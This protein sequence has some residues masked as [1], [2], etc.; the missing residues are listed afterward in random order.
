MKQK[1]LKKFYLSTVSALLVL[2]ALL[3]SCKNEKNPGEY[4]NSDGN[5]D[6]LTEIITGADTTTIP[7][8][9]NVGETTEEITTDM[10]TTGNDTTEELIKAELPELEGTIKL[11]ASELLTL[12]REG[13]V[14]KN[15][16]YE[17]TD[18]TG[19]IFDRSDDSKNYDC[20]NIT[21]YGAVEGAVGVV[22]IEGSRKLTLSTL[23]WQASE[24]RL[25]F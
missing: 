22:N 12:I 14:E 24:G 19:L 17:L 6:S 1:S 7:D 8:S 9:T 15:A 5:S 16:V 13:T 3:S 20:G 2:S 18:K 10:I 4:T 11:T 21:V 23:Q 25:P